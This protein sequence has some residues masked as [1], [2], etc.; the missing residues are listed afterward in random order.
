MAAAS[1]S[2]TMPAAFCATSQ[3]GGARSVIDL[4]SP[5]NA[6]INEDAGAAAAYRTMAK[7]PLVAMEVD[8]ANIDE[9]AEA[10]A[11]Y[12]TTAMNPL[13]AMEAMA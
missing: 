9:D 12:W 2:A 3:G 10:A 13:V 7:N 6:N 4:S 5:A 1:A 8:N 11:A